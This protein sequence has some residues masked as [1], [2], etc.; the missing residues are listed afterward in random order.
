MRESIGEIPM[1][2]LC[3]KIFEEK[4][5]LCKP[6][7]QIE[8]T[9]KLLAVQGLNHVLLHNFFLGKCSNPATFFHKN[10]P[11]FYLT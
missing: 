11:L 1:L 6:L 9:P 7:N 10:D 4:F 5:E 8:K 3:E 2:F